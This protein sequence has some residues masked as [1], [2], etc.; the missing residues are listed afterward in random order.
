MQ[1]NDEKNG[2]NKNWD[3]LRVKNE[4]EKPSKTNCCFGKQFRK[5]IVILLSWEFGFHAPVR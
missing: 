5:A 2:G 3:K 4:K 1:L